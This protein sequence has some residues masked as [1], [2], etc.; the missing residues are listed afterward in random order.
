M[1]EFLRVQTL[2]NS[3]ATGQNHFT[4]LTLSFLLCKNKT[5][6]NET[7]Q[8]GYEGCSEWIHYCD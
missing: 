7:L 2:L 8:H 3:Y 6:R 4:S 1:R 5:K